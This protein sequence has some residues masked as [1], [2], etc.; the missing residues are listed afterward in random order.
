M[1]IEEAYK[2]YVH[3]RAITDESMAEE[4]SAALSIEGAIRDF[5]K[6]RLHIEG[7]AA[8]LSLG[9]ELYA[10]ADRPDVVMGLRPAIIALRESMLFL[11]EKGGSK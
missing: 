2:E 1:N 7:A 6:T 3:V 11:G 8:M 9:N 10:N 5:V 4:I